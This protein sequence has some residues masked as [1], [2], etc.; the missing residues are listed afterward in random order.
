[1]IVE[2]GLARAEAVFMGTNALRRVVLAE[3]VS[4]LVSEEIPE[5]LVNVPVHALPERFQDWLKA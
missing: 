5:D 3:K 4:C 1:M 2:C